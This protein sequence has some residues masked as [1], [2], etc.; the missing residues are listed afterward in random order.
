MREMRGKVLP[1]IES[2]CRRMLLV[3]FGSLL[4]AASAASQLVAVGAEFQVNVYTENSQF[5]GDVSGASTGFVVVFG[6]GLDGDS[7]G[8]A[9]RRFSSAGSAIGGEFL[10]NTY[11]VGAQFGERVAM[12]DSGFVVVWTGSVGLDGSDYGVFARRFLSSGAPAGAEFQVNTFTAD[13]QDTPDVAMDSTGSFVVVWESYGNY[14]AGGIFGRRFSSAGSP[15]AVEFQANTYFMGAQRTPNVASDNQGFV[16]VWRSDGEDGDLGGIFGQRFDSA[17]TRQGEQFQVNTLTLGD[18]TVP[19]VAKNGA[20]FLVVWESDDG[21]DRGVFARTFDAAGAAQATEFRVNANLSAEE[22]IPAVAAS[23]AAFV[24]SWS[25]QLSI[26][27]INVLARSFD[28]AGH[29]T[30]GDV[31][32]DLSSNGI[33]FFSPVSPAGSGFVV[34]WRS[35]DGD[36]DGSG[37]GSLGAAW[38]STPTSTSTATGS[39][40]HSPTR[41][42]RC[43][44]RSASAPPP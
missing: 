26:D 15:L 14:D 29:P 27:E 9:G 12:S 35:T 42:S 2:W 38:R 7:F 5:T 20:G 32:L 28:G 43:A 8:V 22:E 3:A 10:V 30:S 23:A 18:Q 4:P 34:V 11:T 37:A 36:Q 19:G 41:C 13:D 16:V 40:I 24:V 25:E 1:V 31:R 21:I 33:Q 44:T 39:S 6:S 17:G